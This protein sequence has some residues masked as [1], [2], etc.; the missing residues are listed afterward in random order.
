M[1]SKAARWRRRER[2]WRLLAD[3]RGQR[4]VRL[5]A[6]EAAVGHVLALPLAARIGRGCEEALDLDLELVNVCGKLALQLLELE[7]H[8]AQL[9]L[10]LLILLA[11]RFELANVAIRLFCGASTLELLTVRDKLA[12]ERGDLLLIELGGEVV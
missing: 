5:L 12:I 7:V 4:G 3:R 10:Q 9:R 8:A 2:L 6:D 1:D 11:E